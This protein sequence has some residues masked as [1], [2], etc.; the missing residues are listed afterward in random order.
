MSEF[1]VVYDTGS[2]WIV[3]EGKSCT[4]CPGKNYDPATST[5]AKK[6]NST[7]IQRNY[8]Q[9][10]FFGTSWTDKV[11]LNEEVCLDNFE[12]FQITHNETGVSEPFDGILGLARNKPHLF[13]H[14]ENVETS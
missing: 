13:E 1:D 5:S 3:V 4:N 7:L 11:C 12:Y 8:G 9:A 6:K 14:D 2:D 10:T